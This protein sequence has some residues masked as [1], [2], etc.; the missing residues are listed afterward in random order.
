MQYTGI[1]ILYIQYTWLH[2]RYHFFPCRYWIFFFLI[3]GSGV[4]FHNDPL[5]NEAVG[6]FQQHTCMC[7]IS[8]EMRENKR[9]CIVSVSYEWIPKQ[10]FRV[11]MATSTLQ[12]RTLRLRGKETTQGCVPLRHPLLHTCSALLRFT[13]RTFGAIHCNLPK[14]P[15]QILTA[16]TALVNNVCLQCLPS[17]DC[18]HI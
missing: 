18:G 7:T 14:H 9:G 3:F 17:W 16:P 13:P 11:S 4:L 5:N 10:S 1:S 15:L 8:I 12:L 6:G 2:T